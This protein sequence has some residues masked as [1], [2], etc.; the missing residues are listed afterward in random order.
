MLLGTQSLDNWNVKNYTLQVHLHIQMHCFSVIIS[1]LAMGLEWHLHSGVM[2]LAWHQVTLWGILESL[3]TRI[4]PSVCTLY[5]SCLT[6][7]LLLTC[8]KIVLKSTW[9]RKREQISSTLA[10]L[11]WLCLLNPEL[12]LKSLSSHTIR[13]CLIC[14]THSTVSPQ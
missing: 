14:E 2:K 4:C 12:S 8:P 3:L 6:A 13:L 11:H 7:F 9:S 5:K 1:I 10:S